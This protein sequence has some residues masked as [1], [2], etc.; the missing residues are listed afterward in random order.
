MRNIIDQPRVTEEDTRAA[1]RVVASFRAYADAEAAVDRLS[2]RGFDVD[3]AAIVARD[4]SLVEEVTGRTTSLRA[5]SSAH[6]RLRRAAV[7]RREA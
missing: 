7:D 3:R 6:W 5:R 4:L 2:D 1:R